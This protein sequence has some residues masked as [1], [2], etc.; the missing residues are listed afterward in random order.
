VT[1]VR[2]E[3]YIEQKDIPFEHQELRN[4]A[5]PEG[6]RRLSQSG[7]IGM[8]EITYRRVFEN[9]IEISNNIVKSVTL[10]K[11]I[12]EVV[13]IGSKSSFAS[14]TIPGS[15]AYLSAGNAW[16]IDTSSSNRRLVVATGDLDG[17]IFTL[18]K[19][20]NFL[21][22]TRFS[23]TINTINSLWA[24]TLQDDPTKIINLGV[25]NIVHFAEFNPGSNIIAYST[26]EWRETAPGWQANNDLYEL[27]VSAS[28]TVG[29]PRSDLDVNSGGVYGWWGMEFS[30]APD[31]ERLLYSRPDSIG[32]LDSHD[33]SLTSI[34]QIAPYQTGGNWAWVP[35]AAW[36][37]DG[38]FIFTVDLVSS[39]IPGS[40]NSQQFDLIAIP[41][42]GGVPVHVVDNVGMFAY[43]VPSTVLYKTNFIN[44]MS[45]T[46]IDQDAYLIAYL[47]AISPEQSE[48]SGYRLSIIDRDGS[49]QKSLFPEEGVVGLDPQHVVWSPEPMSSKGNLSIALIY[50]GDIWLVN[51]TS[52]EAQQITGDGLTSR[53]DWR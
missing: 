5:L 22:F 32:I 16:V 50:N 41:L 49:N 33:G 48:T 46:N 45:G 15:I 25:N 29:S 24:A 21:L 30:W 42:L 28:G 52:G 34:L 36:S 11:A 26:V 13:M 19:D 12:P 14:I 44:T 10:K 39:E 47:Q 3:Y 51:S 17:R 31:S 35:G 2:E 40:E 38:N 7:V 4:E 53:I 20:G 8:E 43:P 6:E 9:D 37:P 23:S 18:S 1:R 27:A